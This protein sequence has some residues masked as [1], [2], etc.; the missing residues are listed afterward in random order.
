M[1]PLVGFT[2]QE[3]HFGQGV[4]TLQSSLARI[5]TSGIDFAS[6]LDHLTFWDGAGF[7]G[8]TNATAI[9]AA[10]PRL[11]VLISVLILPV[12]HPVVVARQ[13]SSLA[14]LA[15]GRLILGVGVGG[16]DRHEIGAAGVDP[17]TR[18]RRMD[19]SLTVLRAVL[20]GEA[21]TFAGEHFDLDSVLIR[22]A[23]TPSV[24]I[25]IGGRSDAA[26]RRTAK[27]GDGWLAFAC[28]PDRF[29]T[30]ADLIQ[31]RAQDVGRADVTF[32]HG[33]VAWCGFSGDDR[34]SRLA[35]EI[36]ALYKL[37]YD[38]FAKYCFEGSPVEVAKQLA[39]YAEAG[40]Q[41][42]SIIAVGESLS[43]EIDSV[44]ETAS[45]LRELVGP[46]DR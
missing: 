38:K 27:Y 1:S 18:G 43:H 13:I 46:L 33:L 12:R 3:R 34:H 19:E 9:A 35:S 7:D 31:V 28:S 36:E 30:A 21:M 44:S 22:P 8:L 10:H 6:V 24:P 5:E 37:P 41:R 39:P 11:P 23:P 15:P 16:E 17:S 4:E 29:A 42:F 32:E 14:H 26:L 45:Q 2:L 25:L 20:D 40:C